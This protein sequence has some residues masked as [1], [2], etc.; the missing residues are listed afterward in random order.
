MDGFS[1][2]VI[3]ELRYYVYRLIDPRDG[4]TFY[5][6]KGKDNR[7]FEHVRDA[8]RSDNEEENKVLKREIIQQIYDCGLEP[9]HIIHRHG[10]QDDEMAHIVEA[11]VMD[12]FFN[13]SNVV[14]GHGSNQYGPATTE[15]LKR[16]YGAEGI[17]EDM[18][19][20]IIKI[21]DN[22]I[23]ATKNNLNIEDDTSYDRDDLYYHTVRARWPIGKKRCE[24]LNQTPHHVLAMYN[25]ICVG[26]YKPDKWYKSP[27][28]PP[29][30]PQRY[31]FDGESVTGVIR[32]RY[33]G[34]IEKTK[35]P[36]TFRFAGL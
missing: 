35:G 23:S 34:T 4:L 8:V 26:V 13:L 1:P 22:G 11:A 27:P 9:L 14:K 21:T 17:P 28:P 6:G 10:L 19:I 2:E 32:N 25:G 31:E 29:R 30:K 3:K 24:Q 7:I 5:V 20:M 15:Q 33:L 16:K 18:P 36:F 12:A